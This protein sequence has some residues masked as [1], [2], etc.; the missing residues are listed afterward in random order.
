V[1]NLVLSGAFVTWTR[2]LARA[3]ENRIARAKAA[4][5]QA[6]KEALERRAI[7]DRERAE[8]RERKKAK[9]LAMQAEQGEI[10]SPSRLQIMLGEGEGERFYA[11]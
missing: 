10:H 1:I 3:S 9:K 5:R 7:R 6:K 8:K 11:A 4:R 2:Q